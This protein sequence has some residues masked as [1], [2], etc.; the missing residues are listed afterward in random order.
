MTSSIAMAIC[1]LTGLLCGLSPS[2]PTIQA[3]Y[4]REA[5]SGNSQHDPGLQVMEAS[6]E[7]PSNGQFLCQVMFLSK[8]DPSQRL[9]FDVVA[10][11]RAGG[12]FALKSGLC[13]R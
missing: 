10:V 4:E 8:D 6:C 9:Y 11:A 3:A 5:A 1:A 7:P 13:K 12:G 2:A